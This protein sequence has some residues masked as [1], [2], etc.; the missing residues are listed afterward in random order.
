[1]QRLPG[2]DGPRS[3]QEEQPSYT[4]QVCG[5]EG[6]A[7]GKPGTLAGCYPFFAMLDG[8]MRLVHFGFVHEECLREHWPTEIERAVGR[9]WLVPRE[10]GKYEIAPQYR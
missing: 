6:T 1:M 5:K 4:C 9:G 2:L 8:K 10:D 3:T 7:W